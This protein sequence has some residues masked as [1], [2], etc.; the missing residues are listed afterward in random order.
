MIVKDRIVGLQDDLAPNLAYVPVDRAPFFLN[1]VAMSRVGEAK[2]TTVTWVDYTSEGTMTEVETELADNTGTT[3]VVKDGSIFT[4]NNYILVGTEAM[5]VTAINGKNLTVT[6]GQLGTTAINSAAVGTPVYLINDGIE[7]GADLVGASYKPG[8]NFDNKTQI[9][10]EEISVSDTA[11]ELFVPSG[12]GLDPYD[13]EM[14]RKMDTAVAKLE[15]ALVSGVK[16]EN[17][18]KR[19][20]QG[21]RHFLDEGQIVDGKAGAL[22]LDLIDELV[23]KC[24]SVGGQ[25]TSGT[26]ALYLSPIQNRVLSKLIEGKT[27]NGQ[28]E[29]VI[30]GV[31][32]YVDTAQGRLPT[33]I[34]PNLPADEINLINLADC[35]VKRLGK[36]GLNHTFMGKTGDNTKGLIVGE[37]TLEVRNI[38][39]QG[40]IKNLKQTI[41]P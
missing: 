5:L 37:Y 9:I 38:H 11:M 28:S 27:Q 7:E 3:L 19:G 35:M 40:K 25:L 39:T 16:F 6:R 10:R 26:Y 21:I 17:G 41:T 22:T 24:F 2:A 34:T 18:N 14:Q 30:G 15:K 4:V 31:A 23:T 13:L 32:R 29:S 33:I 12:D 8:A 36:R 20:M 1:L